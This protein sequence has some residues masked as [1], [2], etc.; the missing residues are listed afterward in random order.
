MVETSS[1]GVPEQA[2]AAKDEAINQAG[3]LKDTALEHV[4]AMT[5]TRRRR[6][7]TSP[8]TY[9]ESSRRKA[10]RRQSV[11][12]PCL[13]D[14]GSQLTDMANAGQ[15]GPVSDVTRQLADK[16]RQVAS[17]LEEG[18]VQGVGDDLRRFARRQPGLFLAAAGV[19]GFVVTGCCA[20]RRATGNPSGRR[21]SPGAVHERTARRRARR[22][23]ACSVRLDAERDSP[24]TVR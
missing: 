13:H 11:R 7:P 14:V 6:R 18:G 22:R 1:T 3:D 23:A 4:G 17:R 2:Q 8:M 21:A 5:A 19:A 15:P 12:H 24:E 16:S 9:A 20:T 10:T